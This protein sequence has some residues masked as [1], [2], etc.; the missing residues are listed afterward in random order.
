MQLIS[1]N[2]STLTP[3]PCVNCQSEAAH[4]R[5]L[6]FVWR[7][8]GVGQFLIVLDLS[9]LQA[10]SM[11][12]CSLKL[13][14]KLTCIDKCLLHTGWHL[15]WYRRN[16]LKYLFYPIGKPKLGRDCFECFV[17][18]D[19]V[20]LITSRQ[21]M[22]LTLIASFLYHMQSEIEMILI[23]SRGHLQCIINNFIIKKIIGNS[24]F[25]IHSEI[26]YSVCHIITHP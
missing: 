2:R 21:N 19:G 24:F 11:S 15:N 9:L 4:P 20:F 23:T 10:E 26:L 17:V 5:C 12:V 18:S 25:I 16:K 13:W 6:D 8:I 7:H 22:T 3:F 14:N 1:V